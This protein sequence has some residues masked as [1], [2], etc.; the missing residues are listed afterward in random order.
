MTCHSIISLDNR[1]AK[2]KDGTDG[3]NGYC[4]NIFSAHT[5]IIVPYIIIYK[6]KSKLFCGVENYFSLY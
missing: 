4:K 1:L 3:K 5:A 2:N 6:H